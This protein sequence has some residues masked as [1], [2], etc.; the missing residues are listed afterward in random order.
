MNRARKAFTLIELLVV[1]AIIAVL[2]AVLLPVSARARAEARSVQCKSQLREYARGFQSYLSDHREVFPAAD[3]GPDAQRHVLW[4]PAWFQLIERYGFGQQIYDRE[5]ARREGRLFGLGR[6]PEL[7]AP[8]QS[9]GIEWNWD[10]DWTALGCGY[11]RFFLG[12][13]SSIATG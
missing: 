13:T 10:Y 1:V 3:Y 9:N 7:R 4:A 5:R 8:Q 12:W 11:N 2:R 6:C